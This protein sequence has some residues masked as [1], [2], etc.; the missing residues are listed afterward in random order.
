MK[1]GYLFFKIE[2]S[3]SFDFEINEKKTFPCF[4]GCHFF[5]TISNYFHEFL[6]VSKAKK[7]NF[8]ARTF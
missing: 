5:H 1:I 6:D 2:N 8:A 3:L 4:I 7:C